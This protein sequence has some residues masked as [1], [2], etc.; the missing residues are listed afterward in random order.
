MV[1]ALALAIA[2]L[3]ASAVP[4]AAA[5]PTDWRLV[6]TDTF[7]YQDTLMRSQGVATDGQSWFFSWQGGLSHTLDDYTPIGVATL[8]VQADDTPYFNADG[9]NH[10][11][12]THTGDIDYYD[13]KIYAPVEDGEQGEDPINFNNPEYQAPHIAIYDAT[14]LAYTGVSYRLDVS[15][16]SDGVP[17]VAIDR[18]RGE[19][20]T[21]EWGMPHDRLNITDLQMQHERFLKLVYPGTLGPNFRL[22]RVQGGKVLGNTMYVTRDD[23]A[24]TVFS[25]D[26]RSGLVTKLFS[27]NP[28]EAHAELEGLVVR[29]TPDGAL[30]HVLLVLNNDLPDEVASVHVDFEHFAPVGSVP[31]P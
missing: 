1:R 27:L 5:C 7:H 8:P 21:G 4:A 13:G 22:N 16:H 14:T 17:W 20:Y 19:V 29:Q 11:G 26:L 25:I 23:A 2:A 28:T 30:L 12:A 9:T 18:P 31:C 24:K 15:S 3:A 10:V 6:G